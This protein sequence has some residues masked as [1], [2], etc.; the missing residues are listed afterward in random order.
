[1]PVRTGIRIAGTPVESSETATALTVTSEGAR[2]L[3]LSTNEGVDTGTIT[4]EDSTSGDILIEPQ[5]DVVVSKGTGDTI[6]RVKAGSASDTDGAAQVTFS[7]W[8]R[9]ASIGLMSTDLIIAKDSSIDPLSDNRRMTINVDSGNV[10]IGHKFGQHRQPDGSASASVLNVENTTTSGSAQGGNLRLGSNDGAVMG[11][12][13]RLGVVEFAGSEAASPGPAGSAMAVGARIEAVTDGTWS[14]TE[15]GANLDF[16]T[17]DGDAVQTKRMTVLADGNVGIGPTAPTKNLHVSKAS[18]EATIRLQSA[19]YYADFYQ[20][21][22]NLFIQNAAGGGNTIFYDDS[23]ERMRIDTDGNVGIGDNAPGTLLQVKGTAPY[24]TLKN[25]TAE[26]T[27]GGCESKIIFEDHADVTLAQVEGSHSGSSDDTKGKMILST[28]TGSALTAA[29]TIDDA[30]DATFAGNVTTE[31]SVFLKEKADATADVAAYGQLWVNTATPNEL[32][33]TTD[34]G[35]D[36]QLTDGS[37]A[38]FVGDITGVTAGTGLS[39]G[40]TSGAVTLNVDA[41]QTQITSVGTIG[42][43]TWQGTDVGVAHGGTG[44]STLTDGGVLLGSGTGAVTA[45]AVLTDGQMI[46]GDGTTDPVAESGATL[47][48]SIGVG[49]GD[50]PVFTELELSGGGLVMGNGQNAAIEVDAT[51]HNAAGKAMAISAGATTAGTTNN[52]AGGAVTVSGG[53]GKGTGAGGDILFKVSKAAAGAAS[54]L[55]AL[56]TALTISGEDGSAEFTGQVI[57]EGFVSNY[58]EVTSNYT[59]GVNDYLIIASGSGTTVSLPAPSSDNGGTVYRIKRVDGSNS[60]TIGRASGSGNIDG[61]ATY[62]LDANYMMIEVMSDE[63]N[64]LITGAYEVPE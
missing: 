63:T 59:A 48:T 6:L 35:D 15:N 23:A 57:C 33:F 29:V 56:T 31:G 13:H 43:G 64:W 17:T 20:S 53:Q 62:T 10:G 2:D 36:I 5:V 39:G 19:G 27:A 32:F 16:Y 18:G 41:A 7:D 28:H 21:G 24:V 55:N 12:G 11:S 51:A 34:A 38:A 8:Q 25:S 45:M 9:T 54:S 22:A 40:G 42:T 4:I 30:Q 47:R 49:T 14:T 37:A 46:V 44:V 52:I 26:N 60:I 3:I 61:A 1:M 58:R 50:T